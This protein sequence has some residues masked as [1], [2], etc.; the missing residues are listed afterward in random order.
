MKML[1]CGIQWALKTRKKGFVEEF[2]SDVN[3]FNFIILT[4]IWLAHWKDYY[5]DRIFSRVFFDLTDMQ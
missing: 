4:L 2:Q 5:K 3:V 1:V